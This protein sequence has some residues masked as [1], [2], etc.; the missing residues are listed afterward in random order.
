MPYI[1]IIF[2]LYLY[3][4]F[5]CFLNVKTDTHHKYV[6]FSGVSVHGQKTIDNFEPA[7]KEEFTELAQMLN[8]QDIAQMGLCSCTIKLFIQMVMLEETE[9]VWTLLVQGLPSWV[10]INSG[11]LPVEY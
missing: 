6:L 8:K 2:V 1:C 4:L 10:A 11:C 9:I 5:L 7:N 3:A